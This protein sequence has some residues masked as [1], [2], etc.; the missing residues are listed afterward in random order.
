MKP[1]E[2][3]STLAEPA[4]ELD[5]VLSHLDRLPT[6]PAVAVRLLE[7]TADSAATTR[8]VAELLRADQSLT[9]KLLSLA[10]AAAQGAR[11]P[12][13]DLNRAIVQLGFQTVRNLVFSVKVFETFGGRDEADGERRFD[14]AQFWKHALAVACAAQGLAAVRRDLGIAPGDAFVAGLLHDL[15]KVALD[16]VFPKA[17]DRIAAHA[18]Q[19]RGDIADSERAILGVDH[20]VAGR[21][22]AEHWRLPRA[23]R[24]VIWLHHLSIDSLPSSVSAPK[25]VGL[26]QAADALAR[27]RR[28]GYSGNHVAYERA[29]DVALRLGLSEVQVGSVAERLVDDVAQQAN[30]LELDRETPRSIYLEAL[31]RANAELSRLNDDLTSSNRR[32]AA[33]ARYFHALR[34]LDEQLDAS[35]GVSDLVS[36]IA[37]AA[38]VATQ[39]PRLAV[40][41][42][43]DDAGAVDLAWRADD[44][45]A[46]G[47]ETALLRAEFE[48]IGEQCDALLDAVVAR[49][50]RA[51]RTIA[52]PALAQLGEGDAWLLPIVHDGRLAGGILYLADQDEHARLACEAAELRS[53]LASLGLALGRARAQA[54][55]RRLSD[56]LAD[57]NRRL[58]Q[59]Q[60]ELLRSRTLSMIAEMAAGA[61]HELNSPLAVISGRAQLLRE[62][63][64]DPEVQRALDIIRDK[65]HECSQIV[66]ELMDFARPRT[67]RSAPVDLRGLLS[68]LRTEF[69]ESAQLPSSR[70]VLEMPAPLPPVRGDEAQLRIVFQ[71]LLKNAIAAI[72]N[73]PGAVTIRTRLTPT[74]DALEVVVRDRGCGMTPSVLQRAF[75]PFF[76]HRAAGRSRGLGLP[77][78]HRIVEAHSGRVWLE[79]AVD[80]GT[81]AHVVLPIGSGASAPPPP[82]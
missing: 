57:M 16:A 77:R 60:L 71:E 7:V 9:A 53:F 52:S 11:A 30:L 22:L 5:V 23:L 40:F 1:S 13:T 21:R 49:A 42:W 35:S 72:Q 65:A 17:Y 28:I 19:T 64:A 38:I 15:G 81:V 62:R 78:A 29:A 56:D 82:G 32:L 18:E 39:K 55:A 45:A 69:A 26:V 80:E 33:A 74:G 63:V 61:G 14:R 4:A 25:L 46:R 37:D 41:A 43:R 27:E 59:A 67:P 51:V 75:D 44:P 68:A 66:T 8:E 54:A 6:L 36:A 79:S 10:N 47:C 73:T 50:P 20:T 76:S 31:T 3:V 24:E 34:T 70:L 12:I 58:Q 48:S 2:P